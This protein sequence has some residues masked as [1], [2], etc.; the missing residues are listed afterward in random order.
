[1]ATAAPAI[2]AVVD[3]ARDRQL[4]I[5]NEAHDAPQHRELLRHL[6]D[7]LREVGFEYY[8]MEALNENP[9]RLRERG[10]AV[11]WSG[12]YTN[13]PVFGQLVQDVLTLGYTPVAYEAMFLASTGEVA[14]D[15]NAREAVQCDN[16]VGR[17]F[18]KHPDARVVVHEIGRA[19]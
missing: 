9:E 10:C 6:A 18:A 4:V 19:H 3:L 16:L 12:F 14:A 5:V 8:A 17:I 7:R 1:G 13:E 11:R 2:E 15:I